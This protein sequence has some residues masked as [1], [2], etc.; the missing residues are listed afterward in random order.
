MLGFTMN[1]EPTNKFLRSVFVRLE[2]GQVSRDP[3]R[4]RDIFQES[5]TSLGHRIFDE[6]LVASIFRMRS[7][8]WLISSWLV[9]N[10]ERL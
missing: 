2:S 10:S 1:R 5:D 7:D 3:N 4:S 6:F 8:M 9:E